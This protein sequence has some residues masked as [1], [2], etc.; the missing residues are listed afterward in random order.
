MPIKWTSDLPNKR[1]VSNQSCT[2]SRLT[3][4]T[5]LLNRQKEQKRLQDS[6]C[7]ES[8]AVRVRNCAAADVIARAFSYDKSPPSE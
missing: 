4:A 1:A 2:T 8:R 6:H 3:E 5:K 7:R